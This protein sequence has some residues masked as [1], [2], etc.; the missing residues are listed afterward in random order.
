MQVKK[1]FKKKESSNNDNN[2]VGTY[3]LLYKK[4]KQIN[5]LNK[6]FYENYSL[7]SSTNSKSYKSA[8]LK[9]YLVLLSQRLLAY[10]KLACLSNSFCKND[11]LKG[12][13]C[14]ASAFR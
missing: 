6:S 2:L 3:S 10:V 9:E 12:L 4:R 7:K 8:K 13:S 14:T 1:A 5:A 11:S